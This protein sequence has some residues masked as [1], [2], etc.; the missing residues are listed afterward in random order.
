MPGPV[1]NGPNDPVFGLSFD[2]T[3]RRLGVAAG[4]IDNTVTMWDVATTQHP[5]Q[6]GRIARNSQDA[7]PYSGAGTLTPNG[8]VFA[9]GDTV[10]GVQ[11]WDFRD[12]AR[13]VKFGPAL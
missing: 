5:F 13:P 8:R 12:P 11:V 3:G 7:P 6:I 1:I 2:A 10:G 4:A 9:V